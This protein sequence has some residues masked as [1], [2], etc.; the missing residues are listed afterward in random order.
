VS[1]ERGRRENILLNGLG[2]ACAAVGLVLFVTGSGLALLGMSLLAGMTVVY[3]KRHPSRPRPVPVPDGPEMT[4]DHRKAIRNRALRDGGLILFGGLVFAVAA[5]NRVWVVAIIGAGLWALGI[6][7]ATQF[8]R[9]RR[10]PNG[11]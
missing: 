8:I 6:G 3:S 11:P 2:C 5:P 9:S 4:A 1:A 10:G 7:Y